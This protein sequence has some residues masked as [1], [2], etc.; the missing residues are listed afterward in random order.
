[1]GVKQVYTFV[2]VDGITTAE[3]TE[4]VELL[5]YGMVTLARGAGREHADTLYEG[6]SEGGKRH[7]K[8]HEVPAGPKIAVPR[9]GA[10]GQCRPCLKFP[11]RGK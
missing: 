6:M 5:V 10:I 11:P 8:A 1:L 2:P 4:S 3:L 9:P 7:W